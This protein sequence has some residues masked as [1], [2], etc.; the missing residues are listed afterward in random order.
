MELYLY[1]TIYLFCIKSI[2][3]LVTAM[4]TPAYSSLTPAYP[5]SF[6]LETELPVIPRLL[7]FS[8]YVPFLSS[9]PGFLPQVFVGSKYLFM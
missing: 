3:Y 1:A 7:W 9:H 8:V 2:P 6:L 5:L 4:S